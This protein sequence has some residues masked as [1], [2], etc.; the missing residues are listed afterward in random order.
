M[1]QITS[2]P[3]D[4]NLN[5]KLEVLSASGNRITSF[6][7]VG[8]MINL[9]IL[10]LSDNLISDSFPVTAICQLSKIYILD[11]GKNS[12]SGTFYDPCL[13]NLNPLIF[14]IAG[15]HPIAIGTFNSLTGVVPQELM[16]SW[17]NIDNGYFS[18]YQQFGLTGHVPTTCVDLRFCYKANFAYH[19]DLAWISGQP[20]DVP[21][22]VYDTI[23][24]ARTNQR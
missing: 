2:L 9:K 4:I 1:N 24:L 5:T 6:P 23:E 17:T 14:D 19:G 7:N 21:Q 12:F 18:V 16:T 20:S 15:P 10:E 13:K 8:G 3:S 22:A 11:L